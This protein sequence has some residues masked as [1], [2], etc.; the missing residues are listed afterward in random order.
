VLV[1]KKDSSAP[2]PARYGDGSQGAN[3][4]TLI[5]G[6]T[7]VEAFF[8]KYRLLVGPTGYSSG[9]LEV[10]VSEINA[11]SPGWLPASV[12]VR[13]D[14]QALTDGGALPSKAALWGKLTPLITDEGERKVRAAAIWQGWIDRAA[15]QAQ[16]GEDLF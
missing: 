5:H 3:G 16:E 2:L 11:L 10:F 7:D 14:L 13:A 9:S 4:A 15:K 6:D 1:L 12:T 8:S